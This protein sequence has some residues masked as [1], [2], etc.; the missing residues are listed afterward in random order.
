MKRFVTTKRL[1]ILIL[2]LAAI[3]RF[4]GINWDQGYHLHP[5]ERA[6]VMTVDTV[7]YTHLLLG[8][9]LAYLLPPKFHHLSF[10]PYHF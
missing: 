4:T 9:F 7:S 8:C 6:I 2:I 10:S 1:L 3:L 5:D